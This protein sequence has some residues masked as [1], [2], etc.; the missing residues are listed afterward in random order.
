MKEEKKEEKSEWKM[1]EN[2]KRKLKSRFLDWKVSDII[3]FIIII[4]IISITITIIA[5]VSFSLAIIVLTKMW[6]ARTKIP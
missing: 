3:I 6:G 1:S 5:I 4:I 2:K